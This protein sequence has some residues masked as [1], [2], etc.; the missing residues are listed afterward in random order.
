[1]VMRV[2]NINIEILIQ[3]RKQMGLEPFEVAKKVPIIEKIEN[4]SRKPTYK[5]LDALS[6]IYNV[7]K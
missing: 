7:P 6:D 4:G 2:E 5:Q 1:M 3:C